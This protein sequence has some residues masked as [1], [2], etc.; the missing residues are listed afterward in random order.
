M[1]ALIQVMYGFARARRA[2]R[3][4]RDLLVVVG[5]LVHHLLEPPA[6]H[7]VDRRRRRVVA[8]RRARHARRGRIR[9]GLDRRHDGAQLRQT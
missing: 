3:Q 4:H 7:D 8:R 6:R 9:A 1:P 5:E 2:L